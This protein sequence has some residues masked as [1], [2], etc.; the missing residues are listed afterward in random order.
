[1]HFFHANILPCELFVDIYAA[2]C[3]H[4]YMMS[5]RKKWFRIEDWAGNVLTFKGQF[6]RPDVAVPMVFTAEDDAFGWIA[7]HCADDDALDDFY[8]MA[9]RGAK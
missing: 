9:V 8:V 5:E 4:V 1:M 2:P 7:E 6:E 3:H